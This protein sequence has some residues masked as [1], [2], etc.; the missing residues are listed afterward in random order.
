MA[1]RSPVVQS[2]CVA[3]C[4]VDMAARICT[5]CHRTLEEIGEWPTATDDR[6]LEILGLTR[7]R[8][9]IVRA[10]KRE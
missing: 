8:K 9:T 7:A 6:K 3:I 5:G 10:E 2:P 4:K 1:A